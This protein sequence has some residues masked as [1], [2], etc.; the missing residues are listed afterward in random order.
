L[1]GFAAAARN[2]SWTPGSGVLALLVDAVAADAVG[3]R[4]GSPG[5]ASLKEAQEENRLV[6][7]DLRNL[8]KH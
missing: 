4:Q 8:A 1:I 6:L 3:Q 5:R 2:S 7:E